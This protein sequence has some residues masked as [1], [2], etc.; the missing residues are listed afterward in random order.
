MEL[1]GPSLHTLG[2]QPM[3]PAALGAYAHGML[4][5]VEALHRAGFLHRDIKPAVSPAL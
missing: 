3:T 5:A 1:L 2:K 4:A